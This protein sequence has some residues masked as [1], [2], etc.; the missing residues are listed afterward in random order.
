MKTNIAVVI[1]ASL[2]GFGA[3]A[4]D[5]G[6]GLDL[7]LA[8]QYFIPGDDET[9]DQGWGVEAQARFWMNKHVGLALAGGGANWEINQQEEALVDDGVGFV[10][11]FDGDVEL[12]PLG[13]SI[14]FRPLANESITLT[15][16][17]G[18]RYVLVESEAGFE[19]RFV[20]PSGAVVLIDETVDIEDGVV[21]LVAANLEGRLGARSFLFLGGGYQ[22]DI[23]EGHAS[24]RG[25]DLGENELESVFIRG[26]LGFTM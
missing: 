23:D 18:A 1:V 5:E 11:T 26:G 22:F 9:Y 19:G 13:G 17:A 15:L 2:L 16:E 8:G 4:Q 6:R 7:T 3:V 20:D 14:L 10:A 25:Q 24:W 21:G 12:I